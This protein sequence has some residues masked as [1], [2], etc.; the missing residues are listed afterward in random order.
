[1]YIKEQK[2]KYII[3]FNMEQSEKIEEIFDEM[4]KDSS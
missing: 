2:E 4:K 3:Y 1:M